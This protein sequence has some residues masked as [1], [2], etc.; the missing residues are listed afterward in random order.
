MPINRAPCD[1]NPAPPLLGDRLGLRRELFGDKS[2][3]QG[4]VLK[5]TAI[6]VLRKIARDGAACLL[7]SG[8]SNET[9]TTI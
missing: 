7:V 1:R 6:I 9:S 8:N 2:V 5:P 4:N 3:E